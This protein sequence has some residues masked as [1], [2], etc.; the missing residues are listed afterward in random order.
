MVSTVSEVF[1]VEYQ[2]CWVDYD[3]P[4]GTYTPE[5]LR[6]AKMLVKQGPVLRYRLHWPGGIPQPMTHA[7][8]KGLR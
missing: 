3:L 4:D 5:A 2:R 1:T 7:Q 6:Q 8:Q